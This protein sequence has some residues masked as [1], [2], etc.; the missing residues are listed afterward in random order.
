M[1]N[2]KFIMTKKQELCQFK[3]KNYL[4]ILQPKL[5]NHGSKIAIRYIRWI[6]PYVIEKVIPNNNYVV[7]RI[8]TN[9]PHI[10]HRISSRECNCDR[11]L[12]DSSKNEKLQRDK[13]ITNPPDDLYTTEWEKEFKPMFDNPIPYQDPKVIDSRGVI[14]NYTPANHENQTF[15]H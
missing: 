4:Y 14:Q 6:G 15:K 9:K 13:E 5:D 12:D 10:L 11:P 8:N 3:K 2:T 7:R 1:S